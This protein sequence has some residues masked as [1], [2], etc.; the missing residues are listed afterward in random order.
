MSSPR[1]EGLTLEALCEAFGVDEQTI[2]EAL[3]SSPNARGYLFGSIS[4]ILLRRELER[5]GYELERIKEKWVGPKLHHGDYYV[6]SGNHGWFVLESKGVKSNAEKWRKTREAP[7]GG[8]DLK[9]WLNKKTGDI[10]VWWDRCPPARREAILASN[11]FDRAKVIDTHFVSGRGGRSKRTIA[12]PRKDEFHIMAL[13]LFLR[14]GKHE[15]IFAA[16]QD[17][18]PASGDSAHLKQNYLIDILVPGVPPEVLLPPP[19]TRDFEDVF[20]KLKSSVR[21]Q[22]RQVDDRR[23]GMRAA[24]VDLVEL[25]EED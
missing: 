25:V 23:P 24:G 14:T 17:L 2:C 22:D 8:A 18:E 3:S 11:L 16:A 12:T 10:G 6:R 20:S 1:E 5:R 13:D 4:E 15:Y 19:W 21:D 7:K 9:K